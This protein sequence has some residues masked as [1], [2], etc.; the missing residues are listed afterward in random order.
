M[1]TITGMYSEGK[2]QKG[3]KK[4]PSLIPIGVPKKYL[5]GTEKSTYPVPRKVPRHKASLLE[6]PQAID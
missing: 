2:D 4:V 6:S 5:F 3:F 1:R